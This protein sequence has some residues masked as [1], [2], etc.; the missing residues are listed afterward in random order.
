MLDTLC[1]CHF[2]FAPVRCFTFTQLVDLVKAITGWN[3]SFWELMKLGERRIVMFRAFNAREGF[4]KK[5][6]WL[7]ERMFEAI[8]S[9]PRKGQ[10]VDKDKLKEAI[11]LYYEMAGCDRN[12]VPTKGKLA[13]LDLYWIFQEL[14]RH[15]KF[16]KQ[17]VF[18]S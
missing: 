11:D 4:T 2:A 3:T 6:D 9:G 15:S 12:G 18:G 14:E 13:E 1:L 5:D 10:K 8:L 16:K 7:P 17:T